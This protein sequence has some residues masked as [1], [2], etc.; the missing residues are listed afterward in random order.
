VHTDD[1]FQEN[2]VALGVASV[3]VEIFDM[4]QAI[5]S[6]R[7]LVGVK[8]KADIADVKGLFAVIG[9]SGILVK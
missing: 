3:A 1:V 8:A 4:A 6:Q 5:A 7:Q 9:G 2:R